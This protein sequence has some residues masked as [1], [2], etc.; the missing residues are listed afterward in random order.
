MPELPEV[1]TTCR[2]IAPHIEART[3]TGVIVRNRNLR[4]PVPARLNRI[5][6][7]QRIEQV[8]RRGK[9]ILLYTTA[10]CLIMHLGMSGSLG[11][12]AAGKPPRKH[13]HVDIVFDSGQCLRLHD[14]RRFGSIHWTTAEPLE[15]ALLAGLGPEPLAREFD[16]AYIWQASRKRRVAIK[17]FVMNSHIVVGVGNI[18]ASEALFMAGVHPRR[19]A[20][21]VTRKDYEKLVRAIKTVIRAAIRQGGTTLRDFT[22]SDGNPGY[23]KVKLKV[24]GR[25]NEPCTICGTPIRQLV[26][27][28]RASYFCPACQHT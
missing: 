20:G 25:E 3:V 26:I 27:G 11:I 2:G 21:R 18:Y 24:Y 12:T 15:H 10:G 5:L 4:W 8:S 22:Q 28:Q 14:P 16:L 1:E 7:D 9:Y 23:F 6:M 17:S 13:D 19:A